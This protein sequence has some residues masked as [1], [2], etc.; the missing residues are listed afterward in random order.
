MESD[1]YGFFRAGRAFF[2]YK[3][4]TGKSGKRG[5][6]FIL[7]IISRSV[8]IPSRPF[9]YIDEKDEEFILK[10]IKEGVSNALKGRK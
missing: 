7:F 5:Q 2:A 9:L 1:N 4:S 8:K 3:K 10:T 6:E